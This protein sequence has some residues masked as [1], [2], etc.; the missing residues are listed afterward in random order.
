MSTTVA[1]PRRD[2]SVF[3]RQRL[4]P[5]RLI[6]DNNEGFVA[7]AIVLVWVLAG[8]V[9]SGFWSF[10]TV[11]N[12]IDGSFQTALFALGFLLILLTGGIDVSFDAIGIF[13]GYTIALLAS[14]G[15]FGGNFYVT[16]LLAIV[17]GLA[18]G[19]MNAVATG[20]LRLPI[21]IV[22]LGTR[23]IFAGALLS[24]VGSADVPSM[25]GWLGG[26][27][28]WNMVYASAHGGARN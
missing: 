10:V 9:H 12:V 18:L 24:W 13:A 19:A 3:R 20:A 22:T 25:P 17:I 27:G 14:H 21:L 6:G 4:T 8:L 2:E 7:L 5:R 16:I 1:S 11:F 15:T 23:G 26:F 28:K